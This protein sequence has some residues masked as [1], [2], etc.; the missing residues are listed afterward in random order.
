MPIAR[1][2]TPDGRVARFEVPEGTTPEQAQTIYNEWS[3]SQSAPKRSKQQMLD[4]IE[5]KN[6]TGGGIGQAV[7]SFVGGAVKG[8]ADIGAT[9]LWPYDAAVDAIK[10]DR[11]GGPTLSSL[12]TGVENKPLTRNQE[13]RQ[14]ITTGLSG[15][16]S[17][18]DSVAF[19]GGRLGGQILGTMGAGGVVAG[20]L[21]A[22]P[23]VAPALGNFVANSP[24]FA[25]LT[26]AIATGGLR[27]GT[28]ARTGAAAAAEKMATR[29]VGGAVSGGAQAALVDPS[30]AGTGAAI[31][32]ALPPA[33][34]LLGAGGAAV[35]RGY[36][37]AASGAIAPF[38]KKGQ[39][40]IAVGVINKAAGGPVAIDATELITGSVPT[41]AEATGN[42]GI[43]GLQ[44]VVATSPNAVER[45]AQRAKDS[46]EVRRAF[47]TPL[48]SGSRD[49]IARQTDAAIEQLGQKV[50]KAGL[51]TGQFADDLGKPALS[52]VLKKAEEEAANQGRDVFTEARAAAESAYTARV[53]G[54]IAAMRDDSIKRLNAITG[55][56]DDVAA[57]RAVLNE[58]AA[59]LYA[60]PKLAVLDVDPSFVSI[61]RRPSM[62]AA[63]ARAEKL[64]YEQGHRSIIQTIDI[65]GPYGG[66]VGQK[67]QISGKGLHYL[68]MGIDDEIAAGVVNGMAANEK[69]ATLG[70]K[71]ALLNWFESR[72][73]QY[74]EAREVYNQMSGPIEAKQ[75]LQSLNL[76][77][78]SGAVVP[79]KLDAAIKRIEVARRKA[80][81]GPEKAV[82]ASQLEALKSLRDKTIQYKNYTPPPMPAIS[83]G[84]EA[85][86]YIQRQLA[87]QTTDYGAA[88]DP[89]VRNA[90]NRILRATQGADPSAAAD[91]K[92][93]AELGRKN[94]ALRALQNVKLT[95]QYD[96]AT[97][98]KVKTLVGKIE[99]AKKSPEAS[100]LKSITQSQLDALKTIKAD[101]ERRSRILLGKSAG[102][103][104]VQNISVG[105][106]LNN[107]LPG[108]EA[109]MVGSRVSPLLKQAGKMLYSGPD[110]SIL[111]EIEQM[112]LYPE[113]YASAN[114]ARQTVPSNNAL[115]RALG[116]S[117]L[118]QY[119]YQVAP[120]AAFNR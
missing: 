60:N 48:L 76:T 7:G 24:R 59:D 68:K 80:G 54:A 110:K 107:L 5:A 2:Q 55:S 89:A 8:A 99:V 37:T 41:L 104:T 49:D 1:F 15:M 72:A 86:S 69:A 46:N 21:K 51:T 43:A 67:P 29:V 47:L 10:G 84:P 100:D 73:P 42:A 83:Y 3:A 112:L 79:A 90:A 77:D 11:K 75:F 14:A 23:I 96:N 44:R 33:L 95:D 39:Q 20:G 113:L 28:S 87:R 64:A 98:E 97:L 16:G 92:V 103:D 81:I 62:R 109:G 71:S 88:V 108:G 35:R 56:A 4:D 119:F 27:A 111:S 38:T 19:S 57:E 9:L 45:F 105:N 30:S 58:R 26:D 117:A 32:A 22:T 53:D 13:R 94:S 115:S 31:G 93:I 50:E 101:L 12:M 91:Y 40:Q 78:A 116:N 34:K 85:M 106:M 65:R 17:D 74:K 6:D 114:A 25:A 118:E 61:L 36:K 102:S 63:L 70:T 120:S 18:T 52:P 82:S 66:V